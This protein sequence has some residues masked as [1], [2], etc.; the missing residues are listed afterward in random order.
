MNETGVGNHVT[1]RIQA[2]SEALLEVPPAPFDLACIGTS[3]CGLTRIT[4]EALTYVLHAD[5]VYCYPLSEKHF[6]FLRLLNSNSIDL[7]KSIYVEGRSY[8]DAY[9]DV[10]ETILDAV[11]SGNR[12]VYAQQGSPAFLAL[13]ARRTFRKASEAGYTALLLPGV[14]SLEC[15]LADVVERHDVTDF[16][17]HGCSEVATGIVAIDPNS[18]TFLV[19]WAH[20]VSGICRGALDEPGKKIEV[21]AD[22][23]RSIYPSDHTISSFCVNPNGGVVRLEFTI[24]NLSRDACDYRSECTFFVPKKSRH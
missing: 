21:F 11:K 15:I 18:P 4:L 6:S 23:L 19:N 9:S 2:I 1:S 8:Q 13:T 5:V 16:C 10:V 24:E 22:M 14:S 3:I 7:N 20:Y 12:V 17:V